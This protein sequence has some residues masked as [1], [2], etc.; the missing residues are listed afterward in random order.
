MKGEIQK[1][2][3]TVRKLIQI[4]ASGFRKIQTKR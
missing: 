2:K 4:E 1:D 3:K